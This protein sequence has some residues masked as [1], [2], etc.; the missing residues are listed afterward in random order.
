M[1]HCTVLYCTVLYCTVPGED[2]PLPGVGGHLDLEHHVPGVR[3]PRHP[4]SREH[5]REP[6][7][8]HELL[9][10]EL[11]PGLRHLHQSQLSIAALN[12]PQPSIAALD[13]SEAS[14]TALGQ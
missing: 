8:A 3:R 4:V 14:I 2:V 9:H 6:A 10:A 5:P 13:Q 11:V 7:L 12:Q 1:F